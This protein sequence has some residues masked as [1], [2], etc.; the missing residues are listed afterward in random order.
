[1]KTMKKTLGWLVMAAALTIT[2]TACSSD[3]NIAENPTPTTPDAPKTYTMT[4]TASKSSDDATTRALTLDGK[5]LNATWAA[6]EKVT[7]YRSNYPSSTEPTEYQYPIGELTA[8]NIRDEGR[9]C[10][11]TGTLNAKDTHG[12]DVVVTAGQYLKLVFNSGSYSNQQGTLDYIAS[13]CDYAMA[14]VQVE[15]VNEMVVTSQSP[16]QFENQQAI[17]KFSLKNPSGEPFAVTKLNVKIGSHSPYRVTLDNASSDVYVAIPARSG[18]VTLEAIGSDHTG[19]YSKNTTT[20]F[21]NGKYYAISVKMNFGN[22]DLAAATGDIT[23]NNN[24]IAYGTLAGDYKVSIDDGAKVTLNGVSINAGNAGGHNWAG[25]TCLGDAEITLAGTNI[26]RGYSSTYSGIHVPSSKTLTITGNGSLSVSSQDSAA[27]LGSGQEKNN[28]CGNITINGG[29]ITATSNNDAAGIGS[30][31][32]ST[33]GNITINGGTV[34]ATGG[35]GIGSGFYGSCGNITIS[36]GIVTATGGDDAA[37][38]GCGFYG[39]CGDITI[40]KGI[41]RVTATRGYT[42]QYCIGLSTGG[43]LG[44]I[45]VDDRLN[46]SGEGLSDTRTITE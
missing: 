1:M 46:D 29:N 11:L 43:K 37:G 20:S 7:V 42:A 8:T 35:A 24:D 25:L 26:V 21:I 44:T 4:V 17:V 10:T 2:T 23:L 12:N 27:G 14:Y 19:Y 16:A 15:S 13:H 30:G 45:S 5:T 28:T 9:T 36:G 39:S 18:L 40:N 34:T 33:C 41:T 6:G 32:K 38:I 31:A 22:V 3:D